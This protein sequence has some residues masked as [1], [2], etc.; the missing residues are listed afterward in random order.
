MVSRYF[1]RRS[2]WLIWRWFILLFDVFVDDKKLLSILR[3]HR[4]IQQI[5]NYRSFFIIRIWVTNRMFYT[6]RLQKTISLFRFTF[7]TSIPR[8]VFFKIEHMQIFILTPSMAVR[9]WSI[10]P[11]LLHKVF[12]W[13]LFLV[14][15]TRRNTFTLNR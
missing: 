13:A 7:K 11:L 1:R 12:E 10:W 8:R 14:N 5:I 15:K 4:N 3:L 9:P 6:R 2:V